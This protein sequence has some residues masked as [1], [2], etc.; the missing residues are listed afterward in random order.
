M[1]LIKCKVKLQL[2]WAKRCVLS[3]AGTDNADGNNGVNNVCFTIKDTKLS[4][5]VVTLSARDNEKLSKLFSK[6]FER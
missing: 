5:P 4:I 6:R 3:V 1:Q 2:I